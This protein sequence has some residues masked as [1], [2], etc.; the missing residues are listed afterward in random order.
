MKVILRG[1]GLRQYRLK[2][3]ATNIFFQKKII[4]QTE[5]MV[6]VLKKFR[7]AVPALH[8]FILFPVKVAESGR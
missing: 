3:C 4:Y 5:V 2:T 7:R 1:G 6:Y 8:F